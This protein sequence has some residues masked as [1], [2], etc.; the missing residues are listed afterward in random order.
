MQ[1][2]SLEMNLYIE[3]RR[4][5]CS[6]SSDGDLVEGILLLGTGFEG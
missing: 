5:D 1:L 2:I 6:V 3:S 4:E